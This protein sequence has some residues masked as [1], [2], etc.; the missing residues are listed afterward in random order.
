MGASLWDICNPVKWWVYALVEHGQVAGL[1]VLAAE[2]LVV[3]GIFSAW[4]TLYERHNR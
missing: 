3:F 4:E 2:L 1:S